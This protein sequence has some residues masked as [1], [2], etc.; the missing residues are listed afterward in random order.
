[1]NFALAPTD[2]AHAPA[3][4]RLASH[5]DIAATTLLPHPYPEDGAIRFVEDLVLPER[6]AGRLY[7]FVMLDAGE[8]VGHVSLKN[9]DRER[10]EAEVGYWVGRPY[11]GRGY[12][13]RA[14]RD[15]A[16]FAFE[17][18]GLRRLYAHVLAYNPAS[19]RVLEKAG[20]VPVELPPEAIPDACATKG[21]TLG[22]E[23][24]A[25]GR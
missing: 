7:A 14:V 3:I 19:G 18:L 4:Q 8:V 21:E 17:D 20:F 5:P 16:A 1:M 6:A 2:R 24:A 11:W 12:A 10:G 22:Y 25:D 15:I 9:V 13:S 23:L